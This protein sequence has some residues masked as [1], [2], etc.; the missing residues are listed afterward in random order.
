VAPD[1]AAAAPRLPRDLSR[2]A[3]VAPYAVHLPLP[4]DGAA[5]PG[6]VC[7][8]LFARYCVL[9]G[10]GPEAPPARRGGGEGAP[11]SGNGTAPAPAYSDEAPPG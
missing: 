7:E 4:G 2:L 1:A 5:R 8:H 6:S 10:P 3:A 9:C 11:R